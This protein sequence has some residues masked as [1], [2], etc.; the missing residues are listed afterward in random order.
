MTAAERID[1]LRAEVVRWNRQISL[2]SRVD[3]S[4]RVDELVAQCREA[5]TLLAGR[6]GSPPSGGRRLWVDIGS[7]AGFPGLVWAAERAECW[8]ED[9]WLLVEP[10]EKRAWFLNRCGREMGL[11]GGGVVME[12]WGDGALGLPAA[13]APILDVVLSIKALS[14]S[15]DE[16]LAGLMGYGEI[17]DS[18]Q[19][20]AIGR[21]LGSEERSLA[22]WLSI[23]APRRDTGGRW[24][25]RDGGVLVGQRG[26]LLLTRYARRIV[27]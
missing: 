12:R 27:S 14:L 20:V 19:S 6:M 17:T 11:D 18:V 1:R 25:F 2:V 26:R 7:G 4:S 15:D 23:H 8:P 22:E 9:P 3:T 24:L 10:R 5:W 13:L 21:F 16:V